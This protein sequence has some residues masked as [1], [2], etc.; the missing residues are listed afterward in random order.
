MELLV[1]GRCCDHLHLHRYYSHTEAYLKAVALRRM[2]PNLQT[3]DMVRAG[4][5]W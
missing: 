5:C 1:R 4:E 2:P 3:V